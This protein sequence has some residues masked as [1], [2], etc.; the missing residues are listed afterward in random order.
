MEKV[1]QINDDILNDTL[2]DYD[3]ESMNIIID[4]DGFYKEHKTSKIYW[5][6]GDSI[7]QLLI[8]FDKKKVYNLWQ[9]YP[10]NMS[11]EEIEIFNKEEPY[12]AVFF[13]NRLNTQQIK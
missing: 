6:K 2:D 3:E 10:Q 4:A 9:D 7:G 1:E 12:W 13:S 11:K 8:S 5:K